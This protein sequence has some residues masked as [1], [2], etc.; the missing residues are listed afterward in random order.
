VAL[1]MLVMVEEVIHQ[2]ALVVFMDRCFS[3]RFM[4]VL[5]GMGFIMVC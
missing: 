1:G 4:V 5:A 2:T 3:H